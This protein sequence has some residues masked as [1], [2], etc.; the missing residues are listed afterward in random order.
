MNKEK[1][2]AQTIILDR[3]TWLTLA[4]YLKK[5][6]SVPPLKYEDIK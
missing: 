1:K 3:S 5:L 6:N 2:S 4:E